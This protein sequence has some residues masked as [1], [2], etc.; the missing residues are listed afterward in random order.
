RDANALAFAREGDSTGALRIPRRLGNSQT[1]TAGL[2]L[3]LPRA[4][5]LYTDSESFLRGVL[6][7]LQPIDVNFNRS[8]LS[9]Y[10]GSAVP[11]TLASQFGVGGINNFRQLRGDLST[12]FGL[13]TQL[14]LIQSLIL[15]LCASRSRCHK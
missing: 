7:G 1:T 2:T 15:S 5:K 8:V 11:A 4:I 10:D 6:G 9:V 12:S 14:P 13:L 3:D